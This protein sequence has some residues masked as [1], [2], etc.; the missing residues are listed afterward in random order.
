MREA[1]RKAEEERRRREEEAKK[2]RMVLLLMM[3][4]TLWFSGSD[5]VECHKISIL[6]LFVV[7]FSFN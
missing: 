7:L 2:V 4:A 6:F 5:P 1:R 3:M